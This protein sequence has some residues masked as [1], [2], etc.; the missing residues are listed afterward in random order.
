VLIDYLP[1]FIVHVVGLANDALRSNACGRRGVTRDVDAADGGAGTETSL[2]LN[3]TRDTDVTDDE[4][5]ENDE[6][7]GCNGANERRG[8]AG[9]NGSNGIPLSDVVGAARGGDRGTNGPNDDRRRSRSL[10]DGV[11]APPYERRL[12]SGAAAPDNSSTSVAIDDED[13]H[14]GVSSV[15]STGVHLSLLSLIRVSGGAAILETPRFS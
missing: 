4:D 13:E 2:P 15:V 10:R 9:T 7:D 12:L 11:F 3:D 14:D 1:F 6:D 5:E 8:T